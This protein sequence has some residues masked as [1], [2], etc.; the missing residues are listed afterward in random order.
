MFG[1]LGFYRRN[2][3]RRDPRRLGAPP[4]AWHSARILRVLHSPRVI[5]TSQRLPCLSSVA[6]AL[7]VLESSLNSSVFDLNIRGALMLSNMGFRP[8]G[9]NLLLIMFDENNKDKNHL[10][11]TQLDELLEGLH[12][13]Q[14]KILGISHNSKRW[15]VDM[16]VFTAFFAS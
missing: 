3:H 2:P 5:S 12:V 10:V 9:T 7:H 14:T 1:V 8:L 16:T 15:N 6:L 13:E 4:F 11:E